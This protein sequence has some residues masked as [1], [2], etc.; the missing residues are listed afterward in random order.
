MAREFCDQGRVKVNEH[1]AKASHQVAPGDVLTVDFGYK[2][3][4][5]KVLEL[6]VP[7]AARETPP[8]ETLS[9]WKPT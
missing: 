3:T 5:F 4:R 8:Y 6:P 2:T 9:E 7:G 1:L